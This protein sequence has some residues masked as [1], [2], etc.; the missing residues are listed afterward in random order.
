MNIFSKLTLKTLKENRTRTLVTIA[1]I[2]ISAAMFTAI[3]TLIV[4]LQTYMYNSTGATEGFF[5]GKIM[6]I[7]QEEVNEYKKNEHLESYFTS[8][9]IGYAEIEGIENE[10]KPYLFLMEPDENFLKNMP[11][12]VTT[13]HLPQNDSEILIPDHLSSNGGVKLEMGQQ[14][15][16][17]VGKRVSEGYYFWQDTPYH[18]YENVDK[19]EYIEK[20][21][22]KT[23]TVC[24][25]YERASKSDCSFE[26]YSAPGYTAIVK[27]QNVKNAPIDFYYT[28]DSA[29]NA[30]D[31]YNQMVGKAN[32]YENTDLLMAQGAYNNDNFNIVLYSLAAILI[33][34]IVFASVAL[35]YNAFA[36]SVSSRTKQFG[37]LSSIGATKR[38]MKSMVF[39]E[40]VF[41]SIIG[42][43]IGVL[44][45]LGG[46]GVTLKLIGDKFSFMG[47]GNESIKMTMDFS[48]LSVIIAAV[49]AFVTVLIS[50]YI[51][52]KRCAKVT[53]IEAIRQNKDIKTEKHREIKTSKF[54]GKLF[55]FSG[56]LAQKYMG[57]DKKKYRTVTAS[58]AMSVIL[59]ISSGAFSVNLISS[60]TGMLTDGNADLMYIINSN[61]NS[62][63]YKDITA[64]FELAEKTAEEAVKL[65]YAKEYIIRSTLSYYGEPQGGKATNSSDTASVE[66]CFV[67]D[68]AFDSYAKKIGADPADFKDSENPK[69]IL[70]AKAKKQ[71]D[72]TTKKY[73][74][75]DIFEETPDSFTG[76]YFVVDDLMDLEERNKPL[77]CYVGAEADV[78]TDIYYNMD[79]T[80]RELIYPVSVY[81]SF[82]LDNPFH[83]GV[84]TLFISERPD[85]LQSYILSDGKGT[86]DGISVT[87]IYSN[88]KNGRD[89]ATVIT[90]FAYGFITLIALIAVANIFNTVSTGIILRRKEFAMLKSVGMTDKGVVKILLLESIMS[91]IKSLIIGLPISAAVCIL[92]N[93]AIKQGV[94]TSF[95]IPWASVI[96]AVAGVFAVMFISMLYAAKK[97]KKENILDSIRDENI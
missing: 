58:L 69:G 86:G 8:R 81:K 20:N 53:A 73:K 92:I 85:T 97:L 16:L 72:Q 52:S 76:T 59:I 36:I 18:L 48:P 38:Q 37:L 7:T 40:A 44:C 46:I 79:T 42:I 83:Y 65:G 47:I 63:T 94:E 49:I 41:L 21:F 70:Y 74:S 6:S 19:A 24:G 57:R 14:I 17:Q 67:N 5:H 55:G 27:D 26:P 77:T 4:S 28:M 34:I 11:I 68:E 23:Y 43:P 13:G 35:I 62:D 15:T 10:A 60:A 3:T 31:F 56:M 12:N 1:G 30:I 22:T 25:F 88:T 78:Q 96:G 33:A 66:I 91:G 71:Y 2:I 82:G 51:P 90:V 50:A 32:I 80:V 54:F 9:S 84:I 29:N 93:L 75:Y 87:N 39:R 95:L 61:G 64:G 89:M 45:G